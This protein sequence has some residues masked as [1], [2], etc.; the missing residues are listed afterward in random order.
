LQ[1]PDRLLLL[2]P[3]C[4]SRNFNPPN[5]NIQ[6]IAH[7]AADFNAAHD[8]DVSAALKLTELVI[9]HAHIVQ[10][11]RKEAADPQLALPLEVTE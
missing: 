6:A 9:R 1:A 8:Y 5:M 11:A 2:P 4:T 7:A 3:N 10:L